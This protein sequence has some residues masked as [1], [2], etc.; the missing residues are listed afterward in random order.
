M[1]QFP[2]TLNPEEIHSKKLLNITDEDG[3][4][5]CYACPHSCWREH[6]DAWCREYRAGNKTAPQPIT[7]GHL[8]F[9]HPTDYGMIPYGCDNIDVH[10][11][12]WDNH[13]RALLN[14]W[15]RGLTK[16]QLD[17]IVKATVN[18]KMSGQEVGV[19]PFI[20]CVYAGIN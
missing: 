3:P 13:I 11:V 18:A 17:K 15:D 14:G 5:V 16:E 12:A 6:H 4:T 19:F 2:Y 20:A 1:R 7:P 10:R 8:M 9:I